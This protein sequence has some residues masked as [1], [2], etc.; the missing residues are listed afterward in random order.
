MTL[1]R[2]TPPW[3]CSD[4]TPGPLF[5]AAG[6]LGVLWLSYDR[7]GY[8]GST[9]APDRPVASVAPSVWRIAEEFGIGKF[10]VIGHM[11]P[12]GVESLKAAVEDRQAKERYENSGTR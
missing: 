9:P 1:G 3:R 4:I 6:R 10:A 12:A 7:P 8:G 2:P 5:E 11:A